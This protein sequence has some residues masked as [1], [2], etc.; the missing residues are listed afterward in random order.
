MKQ[1]KQREITSI[2]SDL[3]GSLSEAIS[4]LQT[5]EQK[6]S[7]GYRNLKLYIDVPYDNHTHLYLTGESLETDE[8]EQDREAREKIRAQKEEERERRLLAELKKKYEK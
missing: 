4:Y 8:E 5:L 7:T 6:Y 3:E 2:L 1:Y